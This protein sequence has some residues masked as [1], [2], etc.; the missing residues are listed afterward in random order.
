[1]KHN[2]ASMCTCGVCVCLGCMQEATHP[3]YFIITYRRVNSVRPIY[4][5][6]SLFFVCVSL[7]P[8]PLCTGSIAQIESISSHN[9]YD[10]KI[11]VVLYFIFFYFIF[12][13]LLYIITL[14]CSVIKCFVRSTIQ[15]V[16]F[17][18]VDFYFLV[19]HGIALHSHRISRIVVIS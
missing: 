1:M 6:L 7:I 8:I 17:V 9:H 3:A 19:P 18:Y 10:I 11:T 16:A 13:W 15:Y 2:N 12:G 4:S 5:H 14:K